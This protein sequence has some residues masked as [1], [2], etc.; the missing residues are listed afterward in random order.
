MISLIEH[1]V[2]GLKNTLRI[3]RVETHLLNNSEIF[4]DEQYFIDVCYK[5]GIFLS[6]YIQFFLQKIAQQKYS[7]KTRTAEADDYINL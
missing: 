1:K 3:S 2:H 4:Q 7:Y 6:S 5:Q